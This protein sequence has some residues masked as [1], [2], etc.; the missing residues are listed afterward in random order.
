MWDDKRTKTARRALEQR[1]DEAA[2]RWKT[3]PREGNEAAVQVEWGKLIEYGFQLYDDG[4]DRFLD[5]FVGFFRERYDPAQKA[6][7][8]FNMVSSRRKYETDA[9]DDRELSVDAET[10]DG[11][12]SAE[13]EIDKKTLA[14]RPDPVSEELVFDATAA[15]LVAD[16][17]TMREKLQGRANNPVREL[18]F[19]MFFTDGVV[20]A[21]HTEHVPE[22]YARHERALF[23]AFRLGFLDFFLSA[24]CRTVA[25]IDA[26]AV[27][28]YGELVP[29]RE[30]KAPGHPL[31][32]DVYRTYLRERENCDVRSDGAVSNQRAAYRKYL[33][34]C[35]C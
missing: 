29:G 3:L 21:I 6:S 26:T 33:R 16:I 35:L 11:Y 23:D 2:Y 14:E 18:Y 22:R 5:T 10:E 31:P 13:A 24:R 17:L 12:S 34:D 9:A 30:T 20:D 27:K 4:T 19:R 25:A 15:K 32:N 1:F 7:H 8:Y 28:P